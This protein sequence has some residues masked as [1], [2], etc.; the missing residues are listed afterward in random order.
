MFGIQALNRIEFLH[1][2]LFL[3]RDLKPDNF[4]VGRGEKVSLL[5]LLESHNLHD[6]FRTIE[7]V[8]NP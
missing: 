6:R 7:K 8:H 2:K 4:I 5:N 3:H 1:N